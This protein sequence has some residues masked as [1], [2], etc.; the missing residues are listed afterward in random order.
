MLKPFE[1]GEKAAKFRLKAFCGALL[2][3]ARSKNIRAEGSC[4]TAACV[5]D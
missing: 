4:L 3:A 1:A 2:S 5:A